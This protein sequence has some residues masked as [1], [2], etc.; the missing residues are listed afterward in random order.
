MVEKRRYK[1][2]KGKERDGK[3]TSDRGRNKK[4]VKTLKNEKKKAKES[5]AWG[6]CV[7]RVRERAMR[8]NILL[9]RKEFS[10]R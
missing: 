1:I 9:E 4:E 3:M 7:S 6:R 8:M 2:V 5:K 10:R